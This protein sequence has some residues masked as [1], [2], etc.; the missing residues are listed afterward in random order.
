MPNNLGLVSGS[1]TYTGQVGTAYPDTLN[2]SV[3]QTGNFKAILD[4][5]TGNADLQ[6]QSSN[7]TVLRSSSLTGTIPE[8]INFSDLGAG[9]YSLLVISAEDNINYSLSLILEEVASSEKA[10]V[11]PLTGSDYEPS[12]KIISNN[13]SETSTDSPDL[14][15]GDAVEN[16]DT[17][18]PSNTLTGT[19]DETNSTEEFTETDS[20]LGITSETEKNLGESLATPEE[21]SNILT[22][23][24]TESTSEQSIISE[25]E[26]ADD[27]AEVSTTD[28]HESTNPDEL[29]ITSETTNSDDLEITSE[30]TNSDDSVITSETTH[31]QETTISTSVD[32]A[33]TNNAESTEIGNGEI[34]QKETIDPLTG[35]TIALEIGSE[36]EEEIISNQVTNSV[37]PNETNSND[38]TESVAKENPE[39]SSSNSTNNDSSATISPPDEN[40]DVLVEEETIIWEGDKEC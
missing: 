33:I 20:E 11:D 38:L 31:S 5:L 10:I 30:T 29:E 2:F 40:Q 18:S 39:E 13:S 27:L 6:L 25:S 36:I 17:I 32:D 7:G 16:Q 9:E 1:K 4:G 3:N 15:T 28:S 19:T 14:I 23:P 21:S 12:T 37:E 26:T 24:E 35:E 34:N 8:E 22:T